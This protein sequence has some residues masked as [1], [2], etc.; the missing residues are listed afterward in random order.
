MKDSGVFHSPNEIAQGFAFIRDITG[1][2]NGQPT[3]NHSFLEGEATQV[4]EQAFR[5]Y[6]KGKIKKGVTTPTKQKKRIEV[7]Q[8]LQQVEETRN[9]L[10]Y[11][12]SYTLTNI[13]S[14]SEDFTQALIDA[15][16][17]PSLG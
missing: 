13:S 3:V 11:M 4:S 5:N 17:D 15:G 7:S 2:T 12:L 16:V 6:I 8:Q 1:E 9:A 10:A 14:Q